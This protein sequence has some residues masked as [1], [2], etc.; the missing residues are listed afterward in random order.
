MSQTVF[1][2]R[3]I[4]LL[5]FLTLI[6]GTNWPL[7]AIVLKELSVWT[8]RAISLAGAGLFLLGIARARGL[9]ITV[10]PLHRR[11]LALGAFCYLLVWNVASAYSAKTIASGQSAVLGF[12]MPLWSALLSAVFL[13]ERLRGRALLAIALG[14]A[15]V[16]LLLV[17]GLHAYAQAPFG[18]AA[19][20]L[21]GLGWAVG[22]L[23]L[24]RHPVPVPGLVLTGWQLLLAALPLALV[25]LWSGQGQWGLPSPRVI[26]L[27]AYITFIPM[28]LGNLAWFSIVGLLPAN[29]A[30]LS[31]VMVPVV[32]M[33]SGAVVRGEP[34]G[35]PQ[36]AAMACCVGALALS[37]LKPAVN[38][39]AER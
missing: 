37:V 18:F 10:E 29:V 26:G 32:A 31:T 9:S 1:P 27:T 38:R 39:A 16:G 21:A 23:I 12:T 2:P 25:A 13:G 4:A 15:G 33:I 34:L 7:F 30:G 28:A 14:T 19:G 24:K 17:P 35:P 6:W 36:L 8:F 22:T 20:L 5:V 11:T 3:A